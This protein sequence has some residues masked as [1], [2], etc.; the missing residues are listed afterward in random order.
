MK[1]KEEKKDEKAIDFKEK[2][3]KAKE[4][5]IEKVVSKAMKGPTGSG[6]NS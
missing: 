2:S 5:A 6:P 1:P 3:Q 4:K